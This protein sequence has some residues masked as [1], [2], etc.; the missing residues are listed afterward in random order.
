MQVGSSAEYTSP[1][2]IKPWIKWLHRA[3][4]FY[5]RVFSSSLTPRLPDIIWL[6]AL[7]YPKACFFSLRHSV[8]V[9]RDVH[10]D[11][12]VYVV[13]CAGASEV[14]ASNAQAASSVLASFAVSGLVLWNA[15]WSTELNALQETVTRRHRTREAFPPDSSHDSS[16]T[17]GP[18]T[19]TEALPVFV[20]RLVHQSQSNASQFSCPVYRSFQS[21]QSF[22]DPVV[23]LVT[24]TVDRGST[25]TASD[26]AMFLSDDIDA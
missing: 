14:S 26:V 10:V 5:Q 4:V 16:A 25:L 15:A 8:A 1:S 7:R 12:L 21:K 2:R 20:L 6:P 13:E 18:A 17:T 9:E 23:H 22:E 24:P 3:V 19:F 11:E